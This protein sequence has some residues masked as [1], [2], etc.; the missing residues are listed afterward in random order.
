M[1]NKG[2]NGINDGESTYGRFAAKAAIAIDPD[3]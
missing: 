3:V 2:D 1:R